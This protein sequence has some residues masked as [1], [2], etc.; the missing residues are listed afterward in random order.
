M[1]F[2]ASLPALTLRLPSQCPLWLE[3]SLLHS[4]NRRRP[5]APRHVKPLSCVSLCPLFAHWFR[6][7]SILSSLFCKNR[8]VWVGGLQQMEYEVHFASSD[9]W[10]ASSGAILAK[11]INKGL[12]PPSRLNSSV[13]Q[14]SAPGLFPS[15]A[16]L[17]CYRAPTGRCSYFSSATRPAS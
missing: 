15:R 5:R 13:R 2:A 4:C 1:I 16:S 7:F 14:L 17:Q 11:P 10:V 6:L 8:G 12:Q 3:K 9:L